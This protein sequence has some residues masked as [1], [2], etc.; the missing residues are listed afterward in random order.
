VEEPRRGNEHTGHSR[1]VANQGRP[2]ACARAASVSLE[3]G[4]APGRLARMDRIPVGRL[5]ALAA[6]AASGFA[7][8]RPAPVHADA[9]ALSTVGPFASGS[10]ARGPLAAD[11]P[12][13]AFDATPTEQHEPNERTDHHEDP[14]ARDDSGGAD[15]ASKPG[16]SRVHWDGCSRSPLLVDLFRAGLARRVGPELIELRL[17]F[18][19]NFAS[20]AAPDA[21]GNDVTARLHLRTDGRR[22]LLVGAEVATHPWG[23]EPGG[24]AGAR[25]SRG[26]G[27]IAFEI[28]PA[29]AELADS[30]L[31]E[32]RLSSLRQGK[33]LRLV[34]GT[35]LFYPRYEPTKRLADHLQG[36]LDP[37]E[38]DLLY[39]E[40]M[41]PGAWNMGDWLPG[42]D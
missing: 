40:A 8:D 27:A 21:W 30:G 13:Q 24:A 42:P 12:A 28:L 19:H 3:Q 32:V 26:H 11:S 4:R 5:T 7:C 10:P 22:C 29:T 20:C 33:L 1:T 9:T 34:R 37:N 31:R 35:V 17:R 6:L 39:P 18:D 25:S 38:D 2:R 16:V 36:E 15:P 41:S 23:E 14:T